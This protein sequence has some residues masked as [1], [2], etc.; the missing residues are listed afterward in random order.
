MKRREFL[1]Q[2]LTVSAGLA[3]SGM[4]RLARAA[5]ANDPTKWRTFEVITRVEITDPVGAVRVWLPV[6]LT[7]NTDYF[8]REPDS[9][10]GNFKTVRSVQYDKYGT[11][12]VYADW[13][14][15]EKAP[16]LELKS[17]FTTRDRQ[18]D[19]SKKPDSSIK[20]DKAVLDY[21]RKPSKL[22]RTDGIVA[23]T[24]RGIVAGKKTEV[25]RARAIYDWIVDNTFRDPKVKGCGIGDI[26]TML[27]TGY[28]GGKCADLNALYVGLARA[29]GLPARDV[30]GVRCANSAEFKSLGRA[31]DITGAQHCRAE[32]YLTGYGWLP[33]DPADV[34][35]VVLEENQPELLPL[36]DPKVKKVRAKLFGAWEMNWLPYN[37]GHD[38][39]LPQSNGPE[40][41]FFMY[42]QGETANGRKDS[43][44]PKSFTYTIKSKEV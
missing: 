11:G 34:R 35:K 33:V 41:A 44:D 38:I 22:I 25:D 7:A 12:M 5:S 31:D 23:S 4:P 18:V 1:K 39:R 16:V 15:G 36:D 10:T 40:I 13:P 19:L 43:L 3:L 6:P 17:R 29:S 8:K 9:W 37:Y 2:G 14:A 21:F 32:V 42:P 20:E 28:L 24:S 27:Q 30:Y 26:S